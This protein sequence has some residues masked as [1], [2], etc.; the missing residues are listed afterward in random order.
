MNKTVIMA[1]KKE[2]EK[3][4]YESEYIIILCDSKTEGGPT[5]LAFD[6]DTWTTTGWLFER[7]PEWEDLD[8]FIEW[9]WGQKRDFFW[10]YPHCKKVLHLNY[11]TSPSILPEKVGEYKTRVQQPRKRGVA[12]RGGVAR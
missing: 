5:I 8:N 10:E 9:L 3:V 2:S 12:Q 11:L 4:T 6:K 7:L 1:L